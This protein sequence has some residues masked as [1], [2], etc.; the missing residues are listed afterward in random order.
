MKRN[1]FGALVVVGGL[2]LWTSVASLADDTTPTA[3]PDAA[4]AACA[5]KFTVTDP[6]SL[7]GEAKAGV[8]ELNV[9]TSAALSEIVSEANSAIAELKANTDEEDGNNP[10]ALAARVTAIETATCTA[11]TNL[12]VEYTAAIAELK[13]ES[14]QPNVDKPEVDKPEVEK[15]DKPEV[16]KADKPEVRSTSD[17][18]ND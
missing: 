14:T 12:T 15:V 11:I 4:I 5:A 8:T 3:T 7:T 10:V 16:E 17:E 18:G 13:A 9:E 6:A 1:V 2:T